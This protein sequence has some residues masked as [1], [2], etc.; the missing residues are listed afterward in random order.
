MRMLLQVSFPHEPFNAAVK[1]GSVGS[2]IG[3]ILQ[4]AKPEA[5]YFTEIDG[6]RCA[7]L[8]VK[9]DDASQIPFYAEPWF[10]TFEA[11][12]RF[13]PVM[14]ADDLGKSNLEALG[15]KWS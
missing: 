5:V 4:E 8:I 3:R 12:V 14:T 6:E 10:L 1:D 9:V 15:K 13:R 11:D 2:K 7:M